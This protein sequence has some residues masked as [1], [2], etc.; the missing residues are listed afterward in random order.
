[1]SKERAEAAIYKAIEA[2][3]DEGVP[4]EATMTF[5]HRSRF[6]AGLFF[7]HELMK[8]FEWYWPI[9]PGMLFS[10]DLPYDLF[11]FMRTNNKTYG[12]TQATYET[13]ETLPS[14]W[15]ETLAFLR[16]EPRALAVNNAWSFV[17]E[18]D[19]T[20]QGCQFWT[21]FEVADLR[22]WRSALYRRYFEQL[23]RHGG[24]YY[25]HWGDAP[26]HTLAAS[27][28]LPLSQLH[29]FEDVGYQHA[30]Y[31]RCPTEESLHTSGRCVCNMNQRTSTIHTWAAWSGGSES[32]RAGYRYVFLFTHGR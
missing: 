32:R 25:D 3:E 20:F 22:F 28:F 29:L 10:C 27:L 1:M 18:D 16:G 13:Q 31:G 11:T 24:F 14:L 12:F 17:S 8:E 6:H 4:Y 30:S 21:A 5:R 15:N 2:S 9:E 7:D 23:D 26:V 19:V